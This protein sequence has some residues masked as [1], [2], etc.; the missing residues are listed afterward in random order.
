MVRAHVGKWISGQTKNRSPTERFN[1]VLVDQLDQNSLGLPEVQNLQG[2]PDGETS[3]A[4]SPWATV[5][6]EPGQE[7]ECG[8]YMGRLQS[9]QRISSLYGK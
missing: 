4:S 2:W 5:E 7:K 6:E 8:P 9:C 3:A 1:Q